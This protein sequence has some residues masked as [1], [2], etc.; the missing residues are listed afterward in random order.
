MGNIISNLYFLCSSGGFY[1]YEVGPEKEVIWQLKIFRSD[2]K[3]DRY[4]LKRNKYST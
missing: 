1:I 3:N 2:L 4:I